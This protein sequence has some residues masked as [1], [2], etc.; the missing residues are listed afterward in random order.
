MDK[1]SL[2]QEFARIK[3]E[4]DALVASIQ[5]PQLQIAVLIGKL[6]FIQE[7]LSKQAEV[8]KATDDAGTAR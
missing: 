7:L 3:A 6:Q 4:H 5:G 8:E 2:E 1:A